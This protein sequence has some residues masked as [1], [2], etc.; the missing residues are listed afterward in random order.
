MNKRQALAKA[1]QLWGEKAAVHDLGIKMAS[2]PEQRAMA[3]KAMLALPNTFDYRKQRDAL[4]SQA[5]RQ[6]FRV[7][8]VMFGMFFEIKGHGDTWNDAFADAEKTGG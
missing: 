1:R 7:G 8:A 2:T 4:F 5:W 6:R 3:H